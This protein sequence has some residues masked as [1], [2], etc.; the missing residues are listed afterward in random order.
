[1]QKFVPMNFGVR[2][3]T[4]RSWKLSLTAASLGSSALLESMLVSPSP[5]GA[6]I[7][8]LNVNKEKRLYFLV[9]SP[10]KSE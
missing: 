5:S 2:N 3:R 9:N 7:Y 8:Y 6:F 10:I 1:M 4:L